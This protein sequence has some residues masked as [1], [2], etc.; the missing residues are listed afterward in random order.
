MRHWSVRDVM[1]SWHGDWF[2]LNERMSRS[3]EVTSGR[4]VVSRTLVLCTSRRCVS[5]VTR[6][7]WS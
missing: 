5:A 6:R 1:M 7:D 3:L 2:V 4:V